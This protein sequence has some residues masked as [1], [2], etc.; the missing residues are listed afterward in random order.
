[1]LPQTTLDVHKQRQRELIQQA[2]RH[3]T[4][5]LARRET[6]QTNTPFARL[7]SLFL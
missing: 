5:K 7:L 2:D 6:K 4:A 1:M 3:R